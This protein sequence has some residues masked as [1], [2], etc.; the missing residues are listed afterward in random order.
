MKWQ[1]DICLILL[2]IIYNMAKMAYMRRFS[3]A[4]SFGLPSL[5]KILRP[6]CFLFAGSLVS[7]AGR[8]GKSWGNCQ[9]SK[10]GPREVEP[11]ASRSSD[12]LEL[13]VIHPEDWFVASSPSWD[14]G[15]SRPGEDHIPGWG[16]SNRGLAS[17][18]ESRQE[19]CTINPLALFRG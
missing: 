17:L 3:P 5:L 6:N 8:I 1:P 16:Q 18:R 19:T 2:N 4:K 7:G 14:R 10:A 13:L 9:F 15:Y 12:D 11:L